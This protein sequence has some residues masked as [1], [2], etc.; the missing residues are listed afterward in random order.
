MEA[1]GEETI[2][3]NTVEQEK[4]KNSSGFMQKIIIFLTSD[5]MEKFY[6][7]G[8]R[9]LVK[10]LYRFKS[11]GFEN[12]PETG[13]AML[14]S[15]HVSYVDGLIILTA[16]KRPVWFVIDKEIYSIPVVKY[17][18]DLNGAIPIAPKRDSVK[19]AIRLV[20]EVLKAG[21]L[22]CIFPEGSLTYTGNMAR[23]RFGIEWMLKENPG[24]PVIPI[25]L[26]GLWGSIFSR[27]YL[28]SRFR[29]F[30]RSIRRKVWVK[31]GEPIPYEKATINY[32]Q[33]SLMR[34]KNSIQQ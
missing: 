13:S 25:A 10:T 4:K 26:K 24:I 9:I 15:N 30:P 18:M 33:K 14:I 27:K 20:T 12:I 5:G 3:S 31:C 11:S 22:V 2:E 23:F 28:G 8:S 7:V 21:N 6:R 34:L 29:W 17:F 16:S 32:M 19:E 1:A